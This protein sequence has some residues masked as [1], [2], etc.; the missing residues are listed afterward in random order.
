MRSTAKSRFIRGRRTFCGLG[1]RARSA[2]A[3]KLSATSAVR[4][5]AARADCG[6]WD[7]NNAVLAVDDSMDEIHLLRENFSCIDVG[8]VFSL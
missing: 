7:S 6:F 8:E 4:G 5:G 2:R 3:E 1:R